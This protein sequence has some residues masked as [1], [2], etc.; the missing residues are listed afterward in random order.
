MDRGQN[1]AA[2]Y[3]RVST[4]EQTEYSPQ[5][6][7]QDLLEYAQTHEMTVKAEHIYMDEGISGKKAAT[8]PEFMRMIGDAKGRPRPFD[9]IL[10]HKFDRF[11][12]NKEDSVLYKALLKKD[13]G[14]KVV[15]IKEPVPQD[16]KFA[17]IYESMLEAMAEYYSLNL[18]EE[19]KKTMLRKAQRGEYQ[20]AAPFGY[21]N[22]NKTLVLVPEEAKM[23]KYLFQQYVHQHKSMKQLAAEL[24]QRGVR[25]HRGKAFEVRAIQYILCNPVYV[26]FCRWTPGGKMHRDF[27]HPCT[28]TAKS[29]HPP[30]I[31][32]TLFQQAREKQGSNKKRK[33]ER[34]REGGYG[35]TWLSGIV[36]CSNC[37]R[38]LVVARRNA[39]GE[40]WMQCGGYNHGQ[41]TQSHWVASKLIMEKIG[42]QMECIM[43]FLPQDNYV[44]RVGDTASREEEGVLIR[45][46]LDQIRAKEKRIKQA[47]ADGVDSLLEYKEN[48]TQLQQEESKLLHRAETWE[49]RHNAKQTEQKCSIAD[50]LLSP[51]EPVETKM[52]IV[53]AVFKKI[54]YCKR[55]EKIVLFLQETVLQNE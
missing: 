55:E 51:R 8:R 22:E 37:G 48:K 23:V 19:V 21:K 30:I 9:F 28:I 53:R 32:E 25:T 2:L 20:A 41:C 12:R 13:C 1:R 52:Q 40:F 14:I 46:A 38:S 3:I 15:S 24:N 10:V 34:H 44:F 17:V 42:L 18:A 31:S 27:N 16:D 50:F 29:N 45:Q 39:K 33:G 26:G 36:K 49:Q 7:K 54:I 11:A 6:Q 43:S 4:E 35:K 5:A 47:Y